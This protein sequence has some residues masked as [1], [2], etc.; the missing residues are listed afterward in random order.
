MSLSK[1]L[2]EK[3]ST[4]TTLKDLAKGFNSFKTGVVF[5]DAIDLHTLDED[6]LVFS[7]SERK[8]TV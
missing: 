4:F 6:P 7:L 5:G 8:F 1:G 3:G 2:C